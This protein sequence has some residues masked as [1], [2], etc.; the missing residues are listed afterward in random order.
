MSFR[1]LIGACVSALAAGIL[2]AG[3]I[4][5]AAE[6]SSQRP[7]QALGPGGIGALTDQAPTGFVG[8]AAC[9]D[10]H[11]AQTRAWQIGRAHV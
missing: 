5:L 7:G 6:F 9:A 8:S 1:R 4:A 10:C 2:S 11:G 3:V